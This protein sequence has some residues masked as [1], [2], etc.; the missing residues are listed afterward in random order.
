MAHMRPIASYFAA[1][2]C[3]VSGETCCVEAD[4]P[5]VTSAFLLE[6]FDGDSCKEEHLDAMAEAVR[7]YLHAIGEVTEIKTVEGWFCRLSAPGYSDCTEWHGPHTTE[8]DAV[9]AVCDLYDCDEDGEDLEADP[10]DFEEQ[11]GTET[12][13]PKGGAHVIRPRSH[14]LADF[15]GGDGTEVVVD[16]NCAKCGR[17]GSVHV[18]FSEPCWLDARTLAARGWQPRGVTRAKAPKEDRM[19][20]RPLTEDEVTFEIVA[21]EEYVPPEGCFD[22]GDDEQDSEI[23]RQI[24][25]D[26]EHNEWA[27]CCVRVTARWRD[28]KADEYLGCCSYESKADFCQREGYFDQMKADSLES[29]NRELERLLEKLSERATYAGP[30]P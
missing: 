30:Q 9:K 19:R 11:Y 4:N 14:S 28:M 12:E 21:E 6:A 2:L 15:M 20:I 23:C 25:E 16:F 1:F 5:A 3:E 17:S 27:W 29:L 18:D 7:P 8:A 26:S 13:C 24:R 22:S 10:E